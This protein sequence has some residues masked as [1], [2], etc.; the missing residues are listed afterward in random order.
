VDSEAVTTQFTAGR[1]PSLQEGRLLP[2]SVKTQQDWKG[3]NHPAYRE[4]PDP[5]QFADAEM[6][7]VAAAIRTLWLFH[8]NLL[9]PLCW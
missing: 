9:V 3:E 8:T 2:L 6:Q 5:K 1:L 7:L 4:K